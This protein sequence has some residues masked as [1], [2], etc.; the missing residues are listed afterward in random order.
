MLKYNNMTNSFNKVFITNIRNRTERYEC[1]NIEGYKSHL[2]ESPNMVECIGEYSQQIK[3][4]FD[5]DAYDAIP[6]IN[7]ILVIADINKIFPD[8]PV[9]YAERKPREF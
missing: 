3:P 7:S 8:K 9:E 5:I 4:V 6:D 1:N 2:K